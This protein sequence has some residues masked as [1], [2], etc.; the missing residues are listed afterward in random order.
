MSATLAALLS[1]LQP[2]W[3]IRIFESLDQ[4]AAESSYAWNNAG[5]GR[6][7]LCELNYTPQRQDGSMDVAK[8]IRVNAAFEVSKQLWSYFV[9]QRQFAAP[10]SFIR[11]TPHHSFVCEETDIEF[12]KRRCEALREHYFFSGMEF[13]ESADALSEWLP[14]VMQ[15]RERTERVAAPRMGRGTDV[16]FG[17]LT[18]SLI[19][20]LEKDNGLSVH[21]HHQVSD[22]RREGNDSWRLTVANT[23]TGEKQ[24]ASAKFV[25]LGAGGGT[26]RLLQRIRHSGRKRV[27][28]VSGEWTVAGVFESKAC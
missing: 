20:N 9:T 27:R 15:E 18:A 17:R 21:L 10:E 19:G 3:T 7:G 6:A 24:F 8:A 12:L 23:A 1:E 11:Y 14:V 26:L 2:D 25:F 13:T 16:N 5:T 28:R 22:I 4:L